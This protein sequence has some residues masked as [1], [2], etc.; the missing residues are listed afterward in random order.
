M[1]NIIIKVLNK[2]HGQKVREYFQ[3]LNLKG[4]SNVE[5]INDYTFEYTNHYYGIINNNFASWAETNIHLDK[6]AVITLPDDDEITIT[7][8]QAR[9]LLRA[10]C[11]GWQ[12]RLRKTWDEDLIWNNN[13]QITKSFLQEMRAA[14][15]TPQHVVLDEV[16]GKEIKHLPDGTPCLVRDFEN[17]SYMLA[18]ANGK[19]EFYPVSLK[20]A[21]KTYNWREV[22][23]ITDINNLPYTKH[24]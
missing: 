19:G 20:K 15:T 7:A 6:T 14:A 3:S 13:I 11:S 1:N 22:V 8:D 4:V 21:S 12:T 23:V 9:T 18:Y 24:E 5:R 10:A 17:K 16:F 2:E